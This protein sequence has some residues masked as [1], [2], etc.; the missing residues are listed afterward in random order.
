MLFPELY[1]EFSRL[2][3]PVDGPGYANVDRGFTDGP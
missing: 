1:A 3:F 2:H